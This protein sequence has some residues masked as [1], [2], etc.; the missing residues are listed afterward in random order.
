MLQATNCKI[1]YVKFESKDRLKCKNL[2]HDH[3]S[4]RYRSASGTLCNLLNR[5]QNYISL[6]F[7]YFH[8][9]DSKLL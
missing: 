2:D 7:H 4:N 9:Y 5:S 1:C 8:R 6:Y 3:Y